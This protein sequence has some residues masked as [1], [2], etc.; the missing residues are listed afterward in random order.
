MFQSVH[1]Y[2][3]RQR[4]QFGMSVTSSNLGEAELQAS[5]SRRGL[6]FDY[7]FGGDPAAVFDFDALGLGPF[8]D[9]GGVWRACRGLAAV[10]S[11]LPGTGT[12]AGSAGGGDVAG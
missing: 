10:A 5:L 12:G 11:W 9:C 3:P 2:P 6:E 1:V 7:E 8:A 4:P